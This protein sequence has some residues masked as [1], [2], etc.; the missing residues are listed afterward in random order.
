MDMIHIGPLDRY[1]LQYFRGQKRP[2]SFLLFAVPETQ[3]GLDKI[4]YQ[5][6]ALDMALLSQ[7]VD[8]YIPPVGYLI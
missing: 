7:K 6:V 8:E 2:E 1:L 4:D 5:V 3:D